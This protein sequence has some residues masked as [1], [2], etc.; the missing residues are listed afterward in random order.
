MAGLKTFYDLRSR[1]YEANMELWNSG[2]VKYT[3]GNVSGID[4]EHGIVAIK[5][6]GVP[7]HHLSRL[8][9]ALVN[10]QGEILEGELKPSSDTATHL[11]LY[12]AWPDIGGVA[13]SHS[14]YATAWAQ[15]IES[16]SCYGT[17]HADY[18]E[19]YIPVTCPLRDDQLEKDYEKNIGQK[20]IQ[21]FRKPLDYR[22]TPMVLV[23]NHGPF[24]WG[25][26]PKKAVEHMV[27]LEE[28]AQIAYLTKMI[29]PHIDDSH[30][31]YKLYA[32]HFNRKHGKDA[33]YG[34]K[35]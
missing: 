3:F 5:P 19:D 18:C 33:Y 28:I 32:K 30:Y 8:D 26:S 35:R 23:S 15:A 25:D 7:Y 31:Y 21:E 9:I 4:R 10:L 29:N 1:V 16:I 2:L 27:M 6:S 22:K 14:I 24:S 11:E 20:I 12:K 34:Q 17:T 13:H